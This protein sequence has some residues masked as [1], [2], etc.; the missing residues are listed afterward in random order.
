ML[1]RYTAAYLKA[2]FSAKKNLFNKKMPGVI[3]ADIGSGNARLGWASDALP[4]FIKPV[5][6]TYG[7]QP[8]QR[9]VVRDWGQMS[10]LWG[11]M[12]GTTLGVAGG[13]HPVL[14]ADSPTAEDRDRERMA[15][16]LFET[17]GTPAFFVASQPVL[18]VYGARHVAATPH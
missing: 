18:S 3:V 9:G 1:G 12:L 10:Q 6:G 8:V 7:V 5:L 4:A 15:E 11:D 2:N 17:H 14:L 13:D 16:I